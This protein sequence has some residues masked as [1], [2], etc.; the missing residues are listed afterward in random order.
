MTDTPKSAIVL[1]EAAV[2]EIL[3]KVDALGAMRALFTELGQGQ[4]VQP[5][6]SL[7]LFPDDRGD[8]I[9]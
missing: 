9:T 8:F 4:A 1:N 5:P 2:R 3:P 6:Q 7:T